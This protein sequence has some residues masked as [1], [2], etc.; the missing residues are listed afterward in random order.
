[1]NKASLR[2]DNWFFRSGLLDQPIYKEDLGHFSSNNVYINTNRLA[3]K[4]NQKSRRRI[5]FRLFDPNT[6]RVYPMT[7]FEN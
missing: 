6:A 4:W 3:E 2:L 1:M 5:L 7:A